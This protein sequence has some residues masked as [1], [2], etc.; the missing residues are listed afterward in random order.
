MITNPTQTHL[1]LGANGIIGSALFS[2]LQS[3]GVSTWGTTRRSNATPQQ[4]MLPFDLLDPPATWPFANHHFDVVY[5]CAGICRMSL[6]EDDPIGTS[7]INID[8]MMTAAKQLS[9]QGAFIVFLSTNQVFAGSEAFV[10]ENAPDQPLNEY[11]RQKSIVEQQI[12]AH[13]PRSAIVRLTKV[14]EPNMPMI[15]NWI[16]RLQQH[17]PIE[18]FHDMMLAP[19]S[20]RQVLDVLIRVGE[21]K[22]NGCY[23]V[24]G[25]EDVSYLDVA[26]YLATRLESKSTLVHPVSAIDKGIK[27]T[28]LPRFTTLS[29]SSTI[30]ICGQKPPHFS[31]VVQ[32]CFDL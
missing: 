7:K 27:K 17:Q 21:E 15:K 22:Q 16:E 18:A 13:C 28:F 10:P 12:R 20:L 4:N 9:D 1:V 19:V 3:T 29:C 14:V 8:G 25:A 26:N 32:E 31:E 5:L 2:R 30:A 11:G 24:S 23:Q 6:C